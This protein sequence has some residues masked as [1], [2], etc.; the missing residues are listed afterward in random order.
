MFSYLRHDSDID[1]IT[2]TLYGSMMTV[3]Y[4][5]ILFMSK[6]LKLVSRLFVNTRQ[7]KT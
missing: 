6:A 3:G 5:T 2:R 4:I 1:K 7:L